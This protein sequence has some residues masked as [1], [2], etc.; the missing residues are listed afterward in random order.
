M[1]TLINCWQRFLRLSWFIALG[2]NHCRRQRWYV[3]Y[4]MKTTTSYDPCL[5]T[6]YTLLTTV[7]LY[8][9]WHTKIFCST[10]SSLMWKL[11]S[12]Q[13]FRL[14]WIWKWVWTRCI[15]AY[16]V[17]DICVNPGTYPSRQKRRCAESL[18]RLHT[19]NQNQ[20]LAQMLYGMDFQERRVLHLMIRHILTNT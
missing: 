20:K 11:N 14:W 6:V 19:M 4:Q 9:R 1:F 18:C 15:T 17:S 5:I 3:K 12:K 16:T 10:T 2:L 13:T 8:S 7:C